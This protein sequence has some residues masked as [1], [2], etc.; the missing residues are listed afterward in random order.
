MPD[1][2]PEPQAKDTGD[3]AMSGTEHGEATKV[4]N[5]LGSISVESAEHEPCDNLAIALVS[6][7]ERHMDCPDEPNDPE[8]GWKPWALAKCDAALDLIALHIKSVQ[9]KC[10]V[11]GLTVVP[12]DQSVRF[13]ACEC[14][15]EIVR[16]RSEAKLW[17]DAH[18]QQTMA[19]FDAMVDERDTL[20]KDLA[21]ALESLRG[22]REALDMAQKEA[23]RRDQKW[24]D[25]IESVC[26]CKIDFQ[27]PPPRPPRPG[28]PPSLDDFIRGLK[29]QRDES[30]ALVRVAQSQRDDAWK[31]ERYLLAKCQALRE[32]YEPQGEP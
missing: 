16:L 11:C 2:Q 21:S 5:V 18:G 8:L 22:M 7:F 25:G 9:R 31:S 32:R 23:A 20:R 1:L 3:S 28:D 12:P 24:M 10:H 6:Y 17:K 26:G 30:Q 15:I 14:H 4:R 13:P 27:G 29:E 19:T